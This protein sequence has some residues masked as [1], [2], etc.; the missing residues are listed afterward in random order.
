MNVRI[1]MVSLFGMHQDLYFYNFNKV[2]LN[3][4][5]KFLY[6]IRT[7]KFSQ[8]RNRRFNTSQTPHYTVDKTYI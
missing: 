7:F 4:V 8:F 3:P 2:N 1:K 5:A 6:F